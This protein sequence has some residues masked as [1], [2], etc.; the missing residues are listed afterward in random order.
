MRGT[1]AKRLRRQVYG[2]MS[3]VAEREY[4]VGERIV[5]SIKGLFKLRGTVTVGGLRKGIS[6]LRRTIINN[7]VQDC[8]PN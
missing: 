8:T 7:S 1:V 2:D 3:Q 6:W 4:T 5:K